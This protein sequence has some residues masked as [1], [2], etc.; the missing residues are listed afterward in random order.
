MCHERW[1]RP[2]CACCAT[3][4]PRSPDCVD[5]AHPGRRRSSPAFTILEG[6]RHGMSVGRRMPPTRAQSRAGGSAPCK[7]GKGGQTRKPCIRE[8]A[9][10]RDRRPRRPVRRV[11]GGPRCGRDPRL[12]GATGG[13]LLSRQRGH[14][15]CRVAAAMRQSSDSAIRSQQAGRWLGRSS[16]GDEGSRRGAG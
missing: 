6:R 16:C 1:R 11:R 2:R 8:S 13:P 10:L 5:L 9:G 15:D 14:V 12:R 3:A 4:A 7:A